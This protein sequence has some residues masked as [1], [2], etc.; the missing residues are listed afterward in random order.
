MEGRQFQIERW[1]PI[2]CC[3]EIPVVEQLVTPLSFTFIQPP[4]TR[5]LGNWVSHAGQTPGAQ[6]GAN[7]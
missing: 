7:P 1:I 2:R 3:V 6:P 4:V 5:S